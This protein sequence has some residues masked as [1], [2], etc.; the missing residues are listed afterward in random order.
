MAGWHGKVG[1][2]GVCLGREAERGDLVGDWPGLSLASWPVTGIAQSR[3]RGLVEEPALLHLYQ[4]LE[5]LARGH[6]LSFTMT[7]PVLATGHC[8]L[9]HDSY[10]CS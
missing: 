4:R 5:V 3:S 9:H 2:A 1:I 6:R 10:Q 8:L 7:S